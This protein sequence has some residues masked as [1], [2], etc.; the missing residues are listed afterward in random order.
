MDEQTYF[1]QTSGEEKGITCEYCGQFIPQGKLH[2]VRFRGQDYCYCHDGKQI[3]PTGLATRFSFP[4][5]QIAD[6]H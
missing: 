4:L 1:E 6:D 2:W 3:H 5:E